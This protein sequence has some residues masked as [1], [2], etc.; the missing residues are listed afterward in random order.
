MAGVMRENKKRSE[1]EIRS[2]MLEA[3]KM[4]N[5]IFR[6]LGISG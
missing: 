4:R 5:K 1:Q 6:V 2:V 3:Q